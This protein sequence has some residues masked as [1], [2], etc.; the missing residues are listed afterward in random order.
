MPGSLYYLVFWIV[1]FWSYEK[2]LEL[3][4]WAVADVKRQ[5]F[6]GFKEFVTAM[7]ASFASA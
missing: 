2:L 5:G 3:Q 4:V 7:Q 1:S 6:L